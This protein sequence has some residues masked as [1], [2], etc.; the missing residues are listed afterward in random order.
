MTKNLIWFSCILVIFV[1][2]VP[3]SANGA[4]IKLFLNYLP[5]YSNYGP[6]EA[7]GVALVSIGEAW[8][9]L[10]VEG[11][12][13]LSGQ[14]FEAWLVKAETDEMISLGKFDADAAGHVAYYHELDQI[15][16][17]EYRYFVI[18]IEPEPDPSPA[19]EANRSI[20]GVFPNAE[21]EVVSGTPT[22]TL[23]PGI[24]PTPG[25][26]AT[27]PV[28]GSIVGFWSLGVGIL[29]LGLS[30]TGFMWLKRG[31]VSRLNREAN[32]KS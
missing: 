3:A 13:Q 26:P 11:L 24:T 14:R 27:L 15:P 22:P 23:V 25:A 12:P 17:A 7:T 6:T 31:R 30:A 20:A 19:A 4:P 10:K 5:E 16:E 9:D 29:G 1:L 2:A 8:V 32:R 21:V 28:T 18:T